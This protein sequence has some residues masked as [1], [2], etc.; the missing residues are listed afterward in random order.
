MNEDILCEK[1]IYLIQCKK[2]VNEICRTLRINRETLFELL[3]YI[4][5][6]GTFIN[7]DE[8]G[9]ILRYKF[10]ERNKTT[11]N[12]PI[13]KDHVVLGLIGDTHLGSKY[14]DIDSLNRAY[15]IFDTKNVDVVFHSG[16]LVDGLVSTGDYF[17][18][19]KETTYDG[20]L[21]YAIDRYPK[22]SGK[23][24]SV[25]GNHDDYWHVL[26]GKE[27]IKDI[28]EEREDIVYLGSS[29]R[30]ISINGLKL[31]VLHGKFSKRNPINNIYEYVDNISNDINPN[32][33]HSGH[34]HTGKYVVY[35]G[36]EMFR[37]GAF[38]K[39]NPH[40]MKHGLLNDN[41]LFLIDVYFDD[42]G[43]VAE[44]KHKQ[45]VIKK[46]WNEKYFDFSFF[47]CILSKKMYNIRKKLEEGE[48]YE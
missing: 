46:R 25:S 13:N 2:K 12:M 43:N 34:Y 26:T 7:V 37:T 14:D 5:E 48:F 31:I 3:R 23:T 27:I 9:E 36:I 29:R 6:K 24:F 30:I 16:Y 42:Y 18:E 11:Y 41:S 4:R 20:Q 28:S 10:P 17:K 33:I 40:D 38:M 8:H 45:K 15:D 47:C 44:I 1:L 21:Y 32:I 39:Q 22:Y 19:L 35:S